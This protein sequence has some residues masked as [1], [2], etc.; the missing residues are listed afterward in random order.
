MAKSSLGATQE[1][2]GIG[3]FLCGARTVHGSNSDRRLVRVHVWSGH[4][5]INDP[6]T[7]AGKK[8][9]VIK[10]K[11]ECQSVG[12]SSVVVSQVS[13]MRC[14]VFFFVFFFID[15]CCC[16][17]VVC[18]TSL[19]EC[20]PWNTI[21][22]LVAMLAIWVTLD[23]SLNR[24]EQNTYINGVALRQANYR[25]LGGTIGRCVITL[26]V[27]TSCILLLTQ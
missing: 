3:N 6:W 19:L 5:R 17:W 21:F 25:G 4:G 15:D 9:E 11:D 14:G 20:C 12:R 22:F 13:E 8:R 23:L 1:Q 7:D 10:K 2:D 24:T 16:D 27:S 18:L 26:R